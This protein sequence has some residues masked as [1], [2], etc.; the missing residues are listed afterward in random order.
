MI[1]L[2]KK[3][4]NNEKIKLLN[5]KNCEKVKH[6]FEPHKFNDE[7]CC[8][9]KSERKNKYKYNTII[10][11][12]FFINRKYIKIYLSKNYFLVKNI[13]TNRVLF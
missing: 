9:G 11:I 10:F 2:G 13:F 4:D 6:L 1:S 5:E 8:G 7:V 3:N 12:S